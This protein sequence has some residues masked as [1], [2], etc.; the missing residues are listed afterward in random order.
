M[1][2][3]L[4]NARSSYMRAMTTII[5]DMI[6]KEIDVYLDDVIIKS[7]E[8]L[9]HMTK[10]KKFLGKVHKND[11]KFNLA[12]CAYGVPL[13]NLIGFVVSRRGI[14]L[15]PSNIKTIQELPL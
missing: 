15:D 9:D 14:E 6:Q 1:S 11:L 8:R 5:H 10:F 4:K 3:R 12:K 7:H 13:G 2:F